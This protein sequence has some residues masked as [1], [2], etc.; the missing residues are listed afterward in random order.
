MTANME[1]IYHEFDTQLRQF[2][3]KR[4]SDVDDTEEILQE[5]YL[6]IHTHIDTVRETNKV[7]SWIYQISRNAIIDY[8]R[9]RRTTLEL[10][11]SIALPAEPDEPDAAR[12]LAA[13]LQ[14]MIRCLPEKDQQALL[15]VELQGMTQQTLAQRLGISLSGAK[16]RVQRAREKLREA[17]LDCCHFEFDRLGKILEYHNKC[18]ACTRSLAH[19]DCQV[20]CS[21]QE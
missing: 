20:E 19:A 8:Y 6:R 12:E 14:T 17:L 18:G 15:L 11:E 10:P 3:H 1:T 5:I 21:S 9:R 2:I 7:Q 16:S 4:V 13:S